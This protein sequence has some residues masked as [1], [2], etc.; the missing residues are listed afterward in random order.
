MWHVTDHTTCMPSY[1]IDRVRFGNYYLVDLKE[2]IQWLCLTHRSGNDVINILLYYRVDIRIY[3]RWYQIGRRGLMQ[4]VGTKLWK[5]VRD[6]VTLDVFMSRSTTLLSPH[7]GLLCNSVY[8]RIIIIKIII[9]PKQSI[10]V[11]CSDS[12]SE[13]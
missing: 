9:V 13:F 11:R 7:T 2:K 1:E 6:C 12:E 5:T 8:I 4:S 10:Y 3:I